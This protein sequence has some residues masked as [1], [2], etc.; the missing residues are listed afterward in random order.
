MNLFYH[1]PRYI[2]KESGMWTMAIVLAIFFGILLLG[3]L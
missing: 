3:L 2:A 1:H